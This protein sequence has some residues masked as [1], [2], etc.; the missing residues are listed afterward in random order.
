[1]SR[2]E[3]IVGTLYAIWENMDVYVALPICV[4]VTVVSL[5]KGLS[6]KYISGAILTVL[7]F[8]FYGTF[9]T[10]K[11]LRALEYSRGAAVFL[12]DRS[13]LD[14]FEQRIAAAHDIWLCGISLVNIMGQHDGNLKKKLKDQ[15]AN[16]RLLLV[17]PECQAIVIKK[18][19]KKEIKT[20]YVA[21]STGNWPG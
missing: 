7:A 18:I 21:I 1:M 4:I 13:G 16:I 5:S 10:R 2:I 8:L 19:T 9:K 14:S 11:T 20:A 6:D 12:K 3:K 15:G 17:D